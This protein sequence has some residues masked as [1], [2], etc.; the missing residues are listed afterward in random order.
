MRYNLS[1]LNWSNYQNSKETTTFLVRYITRVIKFL[2]DQY[3]IK[4][5]LV[6]YFYYIDQKLKFMQ[7]SLK[8]EWTSEKCVWVS[9][10]SWHDMTST[11]QMLVGG[12]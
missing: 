6:V 8:Q 3:A 5:A 1:R 11:N 9:D 4:V 10:M 7:M 12:I 2:T